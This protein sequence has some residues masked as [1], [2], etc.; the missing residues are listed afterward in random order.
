MRRIFLWN[1]EI[2]YPRPQKRRFINNSPY[3]VKHKEKNYKECISSEN[4]KHVKLIKLFVKAVFRF[5][6]TRCANSIRTMC[7]LIK[8]VIEN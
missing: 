2:Y 8:E 4:G 3:H 6:A 1:L 5:Y 7:L